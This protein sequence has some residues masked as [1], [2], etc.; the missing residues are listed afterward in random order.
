MLATGVPAADIS[1]TIN[2]PPGTYNQVRGTQEPS[3]P[4]NDAN[5]PHG[6][7]DEPSAA[8]RTSRSHERQTTP[9]LRSRIRTEA[10]RQ[11][12]RMNRWLHWEAPWPFGNRSSSRSRQRAL[13]DVTAHFPSVTGSTA[14]IDGLAPVRQGETRRRVNGGEPRVIVELEATGNEHNIVEQGERMDHS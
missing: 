7:G 3:V 10:R 4:G 11:R 6:N 5:Q 8:S 1:E 14:S 2:I 9:T 12:D 13:R